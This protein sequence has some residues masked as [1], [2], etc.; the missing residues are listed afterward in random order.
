MPSSTPES[1]LSDQG[2][3]SAEGLRPPKAEA[4]GRTYRSLVWGRFRRDRFAVVG[5]CLIFVLWVVAIYAP[6]LAYNKPIVMLQNG[7][8]R[9][10]LVREIFAPSDSPELTLERFY[11]YLL[12]LVSTSVLLI[13]PLWAIV[14][15]LSRD[16]AWYVARVGFGILAVACLVPFFLVGS[17]LDKTDYRRLV[18]DLRKEEGISFSLLPP[19]PYGPFEQPASPYQPPSREHL[20]GTDK[21]GRDVLA[22]SIHGTRVSLSVGFVA[23]GIYITIGIIIG[24]VAAY[25]GGWV[26]LILQRCIEVVMC[27]PVFLLILTIMAFVDKR[28]IFNVMLII[29]LTGWTGVARLVRG[30]ALKQKQLD[31]VAAARTLGASHLRIIFRHILPNSIAPVL[32]AA[33]F[34]VAGA[35]LTE[36]G[37]SFLGFG[38]R[39][40]T[41]S[42]G[43]LVNQA[44]AWPTGYWWL[45][46]F[47]GVWIFVT[48]T[49]YNLVG[50][51][52]R[53][54]LDP[55]LQL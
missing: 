34:G 22:R 18:T 12:V 49:I 6:L 43:E 47:P 4:Q 21:V 44:Q 42:W 33:T 31:Y 28:S 13:L 1:V 26:D 39:Q 37:L 54:A 19:V 30:E 25:F 27:F 51:G 32:V 10:P 23:V 11:N 36:T 29:G 40:P 14:R 55:R 46:L 3:S 48:V 35:I 52:L 38:V 5:L 24:S 7:E 15:L 41:A 17:R 50:E 53:D 16:V 8:L 45:T 9:C 20:L 2:G